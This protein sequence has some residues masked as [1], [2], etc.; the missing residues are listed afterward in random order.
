MT[1]NFYVMFIVVVCL[2]SDT[3]ARPISLLIGLGTDTIAYDGNIPYNNTDFTSGF[4]A[5]GT[6]RLAT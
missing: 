3:F 2:A 6:T 1:K 4:T 5:N